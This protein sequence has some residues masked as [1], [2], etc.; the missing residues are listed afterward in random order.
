MESKKIKTVSR[1][2]NHLAVNIGS[3][4]EIA[5]HFLTH[6]ISGNKV[7]GKIFLKELTQATGTEISFQHLPPHSE[8][9]YFHTHVQNEETYIFL[10]GSGFFQV[11]DELFPITEGSVTRVAPNGKRG[12]C[13]SSEDSMLY[14]VIQSKEN[15][16]EQYST[17]DGKRIEV[18]P[19]WKL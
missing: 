15:S 14:L 6:P 4:D 11:D 17:N 13:N 10:K 12:I 18:E 8:I 9:P 7:E 3:L 19:K 1:G 2:N 16:L 5:E